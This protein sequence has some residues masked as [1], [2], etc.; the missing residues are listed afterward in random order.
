[1][2]DEFK[3]FVEQLRE[4][5]EEDIQE[6][7][8][9]DFLDI[10][11]KELIFEKPIELTGKTYLA[12]NE[13]VLHWDIHTFA[14]IPCA[15]CNDMVEIPIDITNFYASES[16]DEIKTGIYNFKNL[17]RETILLEVPPFAECQGG[18]CPKR[19]EFDKYLKQTTDQ[20]EEEGYQPFADLDWK[21]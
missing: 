8:T 17:L 9:P 5:H 3:I 14:K 18:Q 10:H 21:P 7:L 20:E 2:D 6:T 12:Q 13:L 4:G 15:I 16:L 11:D 1:M 19:K